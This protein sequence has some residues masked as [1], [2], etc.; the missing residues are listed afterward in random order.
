MYTGM[1]IDAAEALRIGLIDRVVPDEELW[2]ATMEL[3]RT[4]ADNAP[5][6]VGRARSPS[7]RC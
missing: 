6:V 2:D 3:A 5:L 1:R 7:P 4:I